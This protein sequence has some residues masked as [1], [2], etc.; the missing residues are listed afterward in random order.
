M[1]MVRVVQAYPV[2]F[3]S[4][5]PVTTSTSLI[6]LSCKEWP[7]D[8]AIVVQTPAR[9]RLRKAVHGIEAGREEVFLRVVRLK[10]IFLTP[11]TK[12]IPF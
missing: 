10:S 4:T 11:T 1:E 3:S 2:H 8:S 9:V 7:S 5:H 12:F 6:K